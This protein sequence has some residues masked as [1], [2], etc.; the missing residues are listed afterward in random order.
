M[1]TFATLSALLPVARYEAQFARDLGVYAANAA[2]AA[3][4]FLPRFSAPEAQSDA[5][6]VRDAGAGADALAYE[7][8]RR[9]GFN[10]TDG[11]ITGPFATG[12]GKSQEGL[13]TNIAVYGGAYIGLMAA[14]VVPLGAGGADGVAAFDLLATDWFPPRAAPTTLVYNG[15]ADATRVALPLP[16]T[17]AGRF[18]VYDAVAQAWVARNATS[19][20][21]LLLAPDAA[22][23]FV[24]VAASAQITR[25]ET[26]NWLLA[27][28]VVIDW[29]LVQRPE[30]TP[31]KKTTKHN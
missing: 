5:A 10:A 6:W 7:G 25:D 19:S 2:N 1:D 17:G 11:N 28:G 31:A 20:A 23:V 4:L 3:R 29:Q 9:F 22:G 21:A 30:A 15:R 14:L 8:L 26:H 12:D 16:R 27:D 24:A 18:D 13:P